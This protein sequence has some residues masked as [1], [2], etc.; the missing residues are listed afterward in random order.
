VHEVNLSEN[1]ENI[2]VSTS[3]EEIKNE[4]SSIKND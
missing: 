1:N 3:T 2:D 4:D